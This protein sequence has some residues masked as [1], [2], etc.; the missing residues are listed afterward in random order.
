MKKVK[1]SPVTEV[2]QIE[3]REEPVINTLVGKKKKKKVAPTLVA[4]A[5]APAQ[6]P[7]T[8]EK[9]GAEATATEEKKRSCEEIESPSYEPEEPLVN[10]LLPKKKKKV[11]GSSTPVATM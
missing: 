3:A 9:D 10:V 6:E 1:F 2:K 4:P 7:S 5:A 8:S 11:S